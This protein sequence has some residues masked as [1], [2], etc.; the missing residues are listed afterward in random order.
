MY[1][2][3]SRAIGGYG[4]LRNGGGEGQSPHVLFNAIFNFAMFKIQTVFES[5][6][7]SYPVTRLHR[8][9]GVSDDV[10]CQ[11]KGKNNRCLKCFR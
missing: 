2:P 3:P 1:S 7:M 6:Q 9:H 5:A 10:T 4:P 11:V 8:P